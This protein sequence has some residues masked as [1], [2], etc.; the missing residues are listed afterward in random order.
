M[1]RLV[2]ISNRATDVVPSHGESPLDPVVLLDLEH[3]LERILSGEIRG[4]EYQS[5]F[6]PGLLCRFGPC[7][8]IYR[9]DRL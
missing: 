2:A 3:G 8:V 4:V 6:G 1:K 9:P 5:C 7:G